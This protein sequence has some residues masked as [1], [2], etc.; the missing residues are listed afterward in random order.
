MENNLNKYFIGVKNFFTC[1]TGFST[2]SF[3][4]SAV[5]AMMMASFAIMHPAAY[6]PELVNA[7]TAAGALFALIKREPKTGDHRDGLKPVSTAAYFLN[8][9]KIL[10]FSANALSYR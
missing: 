6:F 2:S 8:C 1:Q 3:N 10:F 4:F 5:L 9:L 7:R